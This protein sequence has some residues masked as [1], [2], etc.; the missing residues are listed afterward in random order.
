MN[1]LVGRK[2]KQ[3][4][5]SSTK[6]VP[7]LAGLGGTFPRLQTKNSTFNPDEI[8]SKQSLESSLF[9]YSEKIIHLEKQIQ[10][11]LQKLENIEKMIYNNTYHPEYFD[12]NCSYIT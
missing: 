10:L 1:T 11:I 5:P 4:H 6:R 2:R 8:N 9:G 3:Q 7:T 12:N